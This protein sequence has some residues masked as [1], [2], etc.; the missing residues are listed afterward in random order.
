LD[1][2]ENPDILAGMGKRAAGRPR[3]VIGFAAETDDLIR[4]ARGKL[5]R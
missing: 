1:L 3:L 4:N 5:K 2:V